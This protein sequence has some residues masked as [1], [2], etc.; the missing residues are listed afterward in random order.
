VAEPS[1]SKTSLHGVLLVVPEPILDERGFFVRTMAADVLLGVGVDPCRFVQ[2]NQSRSRRSTVR[3]LHGR[4]ELSEAKLVRCARGQV[5]E[6]V[7]DLRP[8]SPTFGRWE[9]FALDDTRHLQVFV[10][11][12][13]VHGF[14]AL[15]D[16]IDICYKHDDTYRPDLDIEVAWDDPELA[17]PWPLPDP[18][19]S[20]R[21]AGAPTL[22]EVRPLLDAWY[23]TK[24]PA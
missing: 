22:A 11:P 20:A 1:I 24:P 21:D 7:V 6:V 13:C 5:F 16:E 9:S 17:I 14:Q 2:E 10:P 23:G 3:G 8:W 15:S 4:S 12:G 18:V 19:L